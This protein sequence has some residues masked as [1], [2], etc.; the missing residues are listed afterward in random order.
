[1]SWSTNLH[2]LF[3]VALIQQ[4]IDFTVDFIIAYANILIYGFLALHQ[5]ESV[6]KAIEASVQFICMFLAKINMERRLLWVEGR[7]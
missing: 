3:P 2:D 1:M 5:L 4:T 7:F 6:L